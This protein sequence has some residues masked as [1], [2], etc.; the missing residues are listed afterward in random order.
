MTTV[1]RLFSRFWY[2]SKLFWFG[3][4]LGAYTI[5]GFV[6]VPWLLKQQL[7]EII[8]TQLGW[9]T[10]IGEVKFNPYTLYLS[11]DQFSIRKASTTKIGWKH[12]HTQIKLL[13]LMTGEIYFSDITLTEPNF[14]VGID[15]SGTLDI[16]NALAQQAALHPQSPPPKTTK[17]E[18]PTTIPKIYLEKLAI[19]EGHFALDDA[20]QGEAIRVDVTPINLSLENFS[21]FHQDNGNYH[22]SLALGEGET[23]DWN[24]SIE[25]APWRSEGNL[26]VAGITTRIISHYLRKHLPYQ[27]EKG[28][29]DLTG[30]YRFSLTN[31][32]PLLDLENVILGISDLA[33]NTREG[34]PVAAFKRWQAGPIDFSLQNQ[35]AV[36]TQILFDQLA[37]YA[38]RDPAGNLLQ[39]M[40]LQ[41]REAVTTSPRETTASAPNDTA[42]TQT[43][44]KKANTD[45][46]SAFKWRLKEFRLD[47]AAVLW[48]DQVPATETRLGIHEI[49]FHIRDLDQSLATNSPFG[50]TFKL[51]EPAGQT[52]ESRVQNSQIEGFIQ[53]VPLKVQTNLQLSS[54]F[55]QILQPYLNDQIRMDL[56]NGEVTLTGDLQIAQ[57]DSNALEGQFKGGLKIADLS[58]QGQEHQHPLFGW[59][60]LDID[61]VIINLNPL[62]I[63]VG[64]IHLSD[65]W[66]NLV[67]NEDRSLNVAKLTQPP[68]PENA[69][70]TV[71]PA[72]ASTPAPAP[73]NTPAPPAPAI[74][75]ERVVLDNGK[76]EFTDRSYTPAFSIGISELG[77]EIRGLDSR[78]P[79]TAS[80][81]LRGIIENNGTAQITGKIN[82]LNDQAP[83]HIQVLLDNIDLASFTP[84]SSR[85]LGYVVDKGKLRVDLN[86]LIN[87][88]K[89]DARNRLVLD[90]FELGKSVDSQEAIDLP[91]KLGLTLLRDIKG[92]IDLDIPVKGNLDDPE[93]RVGKVI[94]Q[95]LSNLIIKSA[96]A[97]FNMLASLVP[98]ADSLET[99]VFAPA[100]PLLD[101][102][103]QQ[104][105]DNLATALK[106]KPELALEVR[107]GV[108]TDVDGKALIAQ[109]PGSTV[110]DL[111]L[112]NIARER[113]KNISEYLTKTRGIEP[114]Q[115]FV[116]NHEANAKTSD[117][118]VFT[119]FSV[120]MK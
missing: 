34:L 75:I 11:V 66:S 69:P 109:K 73:E 14:H 39:L 98:G 74:I 35:E 101:N 87:Q 17:T 90:Q 84:Y 58:T 103:A 42:N 92:V 54:L 49:N 61:P 29:I 57:S 119:Q 52:D 93:F 44:A 1:T 67:V 8:S 30:H 16:Q 45:T 12:L 41:T 78:K 102:A 117:Q 59:K 82:P 40:P 120:R 19:T 79:E 38:N 46:A 110:D 3:L 76:L 6:G 68:A 94:W 28:V 115:I 27:L 97:P 24:G 113:A 77:G 107:P 96:A 70:E 2:K 4:L 32:K 62:E 100:S 53:P 36:V 88:R 95:T 81:D 31:D 21:T 7:P 10:Q 63:S 105:L 55:L 118:G 83:K 85:Y 56:L 112:R 108:S 80:V 5:G 48:T 64:L 9:E 99:I 23:I 15:A 91:V 72:A 89:L 71:P 22:L 33:I 50:L 37:V 60:L 65:Y 13:K 26:K 18:S 106:A 25:S 43:K 51:P 111:A 116:L 86:Y 20:S 114:G 104:Q 47:N